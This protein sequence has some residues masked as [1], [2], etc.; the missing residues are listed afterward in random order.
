MRKAILILTL[1]AAATAF[2][3]TS[4]NFE[5]IGMTCQMCV[6]NAEKALRGIDGVKSA[7]VDLDSN[8]AEV[9]ATR[10]IENAEIRRALAKHGFDAGFS[11]DPFPRMPA[12]ERAKLDI[13]IASKGEAFTLDKH[14]AK[15]KVTIVDFW[16]EWCGP[17][18]ALTPKLERLVR[19][20]DGVA[21]RTI[22]LPS[23]QAES[24]K[25]ATR[26]FKLPGLPYVR[27]YGPNGRFV[28]AVTGNAIEKVKQLIKSAHQ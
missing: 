8:R 15:G 28:G 13:R 3:Q 16:A 7:K 1:L 26:E 4:I 14:L 6:D 27:V 9:L 5:I 10:K 22:E 18:H 25:Q 19:D 2:G 12:E 23:W 20:V 21:L 24:A 17:C 11:D